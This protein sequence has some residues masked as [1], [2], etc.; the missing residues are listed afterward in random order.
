[1]SKLDLVSGN[2]FYLLDS[3]KYFT[4]DQNDLEFRE[5]T[6]SVFEYNSEYK[7]IQTTGYRMDRDIMIRSPFYRIRY[8][9]GDHGKKTEYHNERWDADLQKW[10]AS[11]QTIIRYNDNQS[12]DN[13]I[14]YSWNDESMKWVHQSQTE[15]L[16]ENNGRDQRILKKTWDPSTTQWHNAYKNTRTSENGG[17]R[18][19]TESHSWKDDRWQPETRSVSSYNEMDY[20]EE[21]FYHRWDVASENWFQMRHMKYIRDETGRKIEWISFGKDRPDDVDEERGHQLYEYN[22]DGLLTEVLQLQ[23][24]GQKEQQDIRSKQVYY[25]TLHSTMGVKGLTHGEIKVYPNPF[26]NYTTIEFPAGIKRIDI[27]DTQGRVVRSY[28]DISGQTMLIYQENLMPAMYFIKLY[29]DRVYT[30]RMVIR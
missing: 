19:I 23:D 27:L 7:R 5:T 17:A 2:G 20:I 29:G 9:Y 14:V 18:V 3:I 21:T 8:T 4:M 28:T 12:I 26:E 6:T 25:W 15:F 10:T 11:Q 1:M 24:G 16:Y 22:P 30:T 13:Q